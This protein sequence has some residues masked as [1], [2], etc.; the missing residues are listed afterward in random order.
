MDECDGCG[1]LFLAPA[2][3]DRVVAARDLSS[4]LRL[5]LPSRHAK[6]EAAVKYVRC[7]VCSK[8]MNRSAFGRISGVIVDVCKSHGVW[9][10]AGELAAVVH[11]VEK[12]G[13]ERARKREL[14]EIADRERRLREKTLALPSGQ[15]L[16][17]DVSG[18]R[19]PLGEVESTP[20]PLDFLRFIADLWR[21]R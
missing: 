17:F 14:D 2:M 20:S 16:G 5:A 10:D 8:L 11:F 7:P 3:M 19:L 9:F 6:R 15:G 1:G 21:R 13:L 12:G 4:G 18:V